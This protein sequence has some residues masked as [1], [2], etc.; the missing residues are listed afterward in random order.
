[1]YSVN[2]EVVQK[3][4]FNFRT[5]NSLRKV[6]FRILQTLKAMYNYSINYNRL[7]VFSSSAYV[8]HLQTIYNI[9]N[10]IVG[11]IL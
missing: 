1:M 6:L 8:L 9:L 2:F 10:T 3:N 7:T 4:I 5:L 11:T